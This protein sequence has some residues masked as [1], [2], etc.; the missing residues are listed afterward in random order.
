MIL[1][2]RYLNPTEGQRHVILTVSFDGLR[3]FFSSN[4]VPVHH[5]TMTVE[6]VI[7]GKL[8]LKIGHSRCGK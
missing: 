5:Q 1:S 6:V 2:M 7:F 8:A 3:G 4:A